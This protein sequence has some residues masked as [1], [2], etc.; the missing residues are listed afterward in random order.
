M[1]AMPRKKI[2]FMR[3]TNSNNSRKNKELRT[4][5][6]AATP[7]RFPDPKGSVEVWAQGKKLRPVFPDEYLPACFQRTIEMDLWE[8]G[9]ERLE[10][11][12]TGPSVRVVVT[13]DRGGL[14]FQQ[15]FHDS[16]WLHPQDRIVDQDFGVSQKKWYQHDPADDRRFAE[17]GGIAGYPETRWPERTFAWNGSW[18]RLCVVFRHTMELAVWVDDEKVISQH[19][20]EDLHHHQL[21]FSGTEGRCAG[22]ITNPEP[23]ERSLRLVSDEVHQTMRGFGGITSPVAFD[24]L[25]ERGKREFWRL[26]EDYNLRVQRDNPPASELRESLDNWDRF[27]D[28]V[29]HYYGNNFPNG[30][31]V[32]FDMNREFLKRGGE[33]WF[34]FWGFPEW[35]LETKQTFVDEKGVKLRGLLKVDGFVRAVVDYCEKSK[36]L[37]GAP[38]EIVGIQNES[39][40]S[41]ETYHNMVDRLR[42][43]LDQAGFADV[44]I[45]MSDAN[46]LS[47]DTTWGSFYPDSITRAKTFTSRPETWAKI[48]FA[49]AHMYDIQEYFRDPDGLDDAF[50]TFHERV[51]DRPFLSTELCINSPRFQLRS[52]KLAML[53]GEFYHKNLVLL[54]AVALAYCW[55]LVNVEQP[56]FG[57]TRS[58]LIVDRENGRV[59]RASSHHLRVLGAWSRRIRRGM[60][61]VGLQGGDSELLATAYQGDEGQTTLV[62]LNRGETPVSLRLEGFEPRDFPF[63]EETSPYS[64]NEAVRLED[65]RGTT[66]GETV[67]I[68]PGTILTLSNVP[69]VGEKSTRD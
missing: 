36:E 67:R 57:W 61:R 48:D 2:D 3:T 15:C 43:G 12:F 50:R 68:A 22:R 39:R 20:A 7:F 59:P 27:E 29:P 4:D 54:H 6:D 46:M 37:A 23:R 34:E 56:S 30:N 19:C 64:A 42:E 11:I 5:E 49:A 17:Q 9:E 53:L 65:V 47:P 21:K 60:K 51:S 69:L 63:I 10:W 32:D 31:I 66:A 62:V 14:S 52:Y 16:F 38:P 18:Q 55:T 8:P 44:K 40:Q 33:V 35:M 24:E 26:V 28:A 45:H 1:P 25:S 41:P 13:L 58:L